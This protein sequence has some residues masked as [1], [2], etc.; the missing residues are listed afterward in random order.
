MDFAA[1]LSDI[2]RR[3]HYIG[4]GFRSF[5]HYCHEELGISERKG[6]H[7]VRIWD[8]VKS[9]GL[10]REKIHKIGWTRMRAITPHITEENAPALLAKA[11]NLSFRQ[12]SEEMRSQ[13]LKKETSAHLKL[14]LTMEEYEHKIITEAVEEAKR[15]TEKDSTS[16]AL[17]MICQDWLSDKG[18]KPEKTS[19]DDHIRYLEEIYRVKLIQAEERGKWKKQ[20]KEKGN[21]GEKEK[22]RNHGPSSIEEILGRD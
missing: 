5:S 17:V 9:L 2:R 1:M 11:E 4:W 21:H 20:G 10:P 22:I 3:E 7:L 8:R 19:L 18:A 6:E 15:L 14:T 16:W 13:R 12:L